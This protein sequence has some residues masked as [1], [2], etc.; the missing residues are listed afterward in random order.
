MSYKLPDYWTRSLK[1]MSYL[2]SKLV[3]RIELK[4]NTACCEKPFWVSLEDPSSLPQQF[5]LTSQSTHCI[6]RLLTILALPANLRA[7]YVQAQ[8]TFVALEH[9]QDRGQMFNDSEGADE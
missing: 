6:R 2:P 1:P 7:T 3:P 8:T 9:S 5:R 4:P